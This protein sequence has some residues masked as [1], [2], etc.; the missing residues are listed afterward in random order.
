MRMGIFGPQGSGKSFFAMILARRLQQIDPNL[1]IYT[2]MNA[3]GGINRIDD[4]IEIPFQDGRNKILIVDEAYF[5]LNSRSTNSKQNIVWTKAFALFR[6][7]DFVATI[8]ITHRPR[9]VDINIREQ[10]DY[11]LMC[12]K[13][14]HHFDYLLY[15]TI[16]DL[17]TPIQ[18]PKMKEIFDFANYNTKDFPLPIE[19]TKL[20]QTPLFQTLR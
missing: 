20:E 19:V 11:I 14:Q 16:S 4:L 8:L 2:N 1:D 12:R 17:T 9:M 10:L 3:T 13:N 15:E 5:T 18:I 7:S 6:K